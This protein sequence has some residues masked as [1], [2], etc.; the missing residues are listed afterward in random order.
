MD[1]KNILIATD[2]SKIKG[3][4]DEHAIYKAKLLDAETHIVNAIDGSRFAAV[5]IDGAC[6]RIF[7]IILVEGDRITQD[8]KRLF[9]TR[10]IDESKVGVTA[11]QRHPSDEINKYAD[12]HNV[13][14]IIIGMPIRTGLDHLLIGSV[15]DKVIRTSK[16]PVLVV[17]GEKC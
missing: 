16:F 9:A 13:D 6:Y 4:V 2:G 1:Y 11:L 5:P 14:L 3:E 10:G 7:K 8:E 15:A 17:R 12:T